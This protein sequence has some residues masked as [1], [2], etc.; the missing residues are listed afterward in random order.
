[1]SGR[2]GHSVAASREKWLNRYT[3]CKPNG[4]HIGPGEVH[5]TDEHRNGR[6]DDVR[7]RPIGGEVENDKTGD[8]EDVIATLLRRPEKVESSET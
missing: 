5:S 1:M 7:R 4:E 6:V 2:V 3:P 8:A